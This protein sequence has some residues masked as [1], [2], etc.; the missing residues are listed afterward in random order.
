VR[1]KNARD[2]MMK[3]VLDAS[4]CLM[5]WWLLGSAVAGDGGNLFMGTNLFAFDLGDDDAIATSKWLL[6]YMYASASVTIVSGAVAERTHHIGYIMNAAVHTAAI[7]PAVNHWLW[8]ANGWL[9]YQNPDAVLGGVFDFA[10]SGVVHL[11]GGVL[12]LVAC[13]LVGPRAGRFSESGTPLELRGQSSSFI[14]LG[15]FF[16]WLGWLAFNMGSTIGISTHAGALTAARVGTRTMLGGSSGCVAVT[17]VEYYRS[18]TWSLPTTCYGILSGLVAVTASC[19]TISGWA[20]VSIGAVGAL[21]YYVTSFLVLHVLKVDD[22][23]D[24]F[25]IHA[26]PGAWGLVA[27]SL[28][29]DG[30]FSPVVVGL[31]YG[32]GGSMLG[33]ALVAI[34]AISLWSATVGFVG[35]WLTRKL[36]VLLISHEVQNAG[37]DMTAS[38]GAPRCGG[39]CR[40][41]QARRDAEPMADNS[42][43]DGSE[44]RVRG[45][46]P[47]GYECSTTRAVRSTEAV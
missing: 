19:A 39:Y 22:V 2:I 4:V 18:R 38:R 44:G 14:M 20:A 46:R 42:V 30:K 29:A 15:T 12:A 41:P 11:T 27:A 40:S 34:A 13:M 33:A 21:L 45:G 6:G 24:A 25:A 28:F 32:G 8:S 10:G 1:A 37:I 31:L 17:G 16:L 3:N 35:L 47:M 7:F 23:V 5:I 26:V 43:H 36:G 9:S